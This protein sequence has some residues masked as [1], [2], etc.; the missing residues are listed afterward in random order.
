MT[1][2]VRRNSTIESLQPSGNAPLSKLGVCFNY[3][4]RGVKVAWSCFACVCVCVCVIEGQLQAHVI[5]THSSAM[6]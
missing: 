2:M 3:T 4:M 6:P 1:R 5:V